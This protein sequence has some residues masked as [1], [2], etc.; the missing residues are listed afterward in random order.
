MDAFGF[1]IGLIVANVPEGLPPTITLALA[2][3]VA[4]LARDGRRSSSAWAPSRRSGQTTVICTDKTGTLTA[5]RMRA[6]WRVWRSSGEVG[7]EG[8]VA[9]LG[10][11]GGHRHARAA[12]SRSR[13][14]LLDLRARPRHPDGKSRGEATEI[15]PAPGRP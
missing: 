7:L 3:G 10:G 1:A 6:V 4:P 15:G 14:A 5:N 13:R 12:R 11:G 2:V 8:T 9:S